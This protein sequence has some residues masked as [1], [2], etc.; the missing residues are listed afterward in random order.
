MRLTKVEL[1]KDKVTVP[2]NLKKT[3]EN[4]DS[5]DQKEGENVVKESSAGSPVA[6]KCK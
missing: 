5:E 6:R 1:Q 3:R 2:G 4:I